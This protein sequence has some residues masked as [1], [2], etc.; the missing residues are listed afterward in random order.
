MGQLSLSCRLKLTQ[1]GNTWL[2]FYILSSPPIY[3]FLEPGVS[4]PFNSHEQMQVYSGAS[5][6]LPDVLFSGIFYLS[7]GGFL[8]QDIFG[9]D[10]SK[11]FD[12]SGNFLVNG[13][14][15][16]LSFSIGYSDVVSLDGYN[17][18]GLEI[19][20][21]TILQS[22]YNFLSFS[23]S[24]T[25]AASACENVPDGQAE[26]HLVVRR[27]SGE[28]LYL[29]QNF[30]YTN[31]TSFELNFGY[32]WF[33]GDQI[34]GY[35][36]TAQNG[37]TEG[38]IQLTEYWS[39]IFGGQLPLNVVSASVISGDSDFSFGSIHFGFSF[40]PDF[41]LMPS[42]F[43]GRIRLLCNFADLPDCIDDVFSGQP[44]S[45][46]EYI[47][48]GGASWPEPDQPEPPSPPKPPEYPPDVLIT[49]GGGGVTFPPIPEEPLPP[50]APENLCECEKYIAQAINSRLLYLQRTI[51]TRLSQFITSEQITGR[52]L[53]EAIQSLH[54]TIAAG[55]EQ[56]KP[57]H[58]A[59]AFAE[60][61][62]QFFQTTEE[63]PR[64]IADVLAQ[65]ELDPF[66]MVDTNE[67]FYK[68][69]MPPE[70]NAWIG[71]MP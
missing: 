26:I 55:L 44:I 34:I 59:A 13:Q 8:P 58:Q 45:E 14:S 38:T 12:Y 41:M 47:S 68:K 28:I 24:G 18:Y 23:G 62:K 46:E 25:P 52:K 65:K 17:W 32:N 4:Y 66:F 29:S 7:L 9:P 64:G 49:D 3:P 69:L 63:E 31:Q 57:E 67:C 5:P 70:G 21:N 71:D 56:S 61:L 20:F 33:R 19:P 1:N 10:L 27:S 36:V 50:P 15:I 30:D 2:T 42:W 53:I 39:D 35:R 43:S 37:F 40:V 54:L 22:G 11:K 48:G 51:D 6:V 16:P 60:A